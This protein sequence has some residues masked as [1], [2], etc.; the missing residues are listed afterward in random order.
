MATVFLSWQLLYA[1]SGSNRCTSGILSLPGSYKELHQKDWNNGNNM[2]YFLGGN[3]LVCTILC[4]FLGKTQS[5][6]NLVLEYMSKLMQPQ[7]KP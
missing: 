7:T 2:A 6:L 3:L 4:L 5:A 1:S